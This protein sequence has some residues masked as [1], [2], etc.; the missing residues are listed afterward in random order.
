MSKQA[1]AI[2]SEPY[3][4]IVGETESEAIEGETISVTDPATG[5]VLTDVPAGTVGD[6]ERA[7]ASAAEAFD[8]WRRVPATERGRLLNQLADRILEDQ[9]RLARIETLENGKP[10]SESRDHVRR[11]ARHFEYYGDFAD[12]VQGESIP[13]TEEYVDYTVY[14]P[15]GVTAHIV[16]W[17]VPIYLFARSVAPALA[18]GNTAVVK[19]AEETPL[20]ALEVARLAVDVLPEGVLNVVTGDGSE[21]GAALT[22]SSEVSCVT[23]TGSG[24]TGREVGKAAID[25]VSEVHLELGGKSPFVIYPDADIDA[26]VDETIKGIFTNAGQVCSASSRILVDEWIHDEYVARLADRTDDLTVGAGMEDPNVGPLASAS[27]LEKVERYVDLGREEVGDPVTGG[28]KIDRDGYFFEPTIFDGVDNDMRIA[29]EEIFGPVVT[30]TTFT[31]EEE[32]IRLANDV[33]YG[34]VAGVMT[35]DLGRAHRFA[36]EVDAGQIYVNE[37]FAGGNET[38]FGG[39]KDSGIGRENGLQAVEN[40]TQLKNVCLNISR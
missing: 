19:P 27:H 7:V 4:L 28:K 39:F 24:P 31:T 5:T 26:A 34:L 22:G 32:A 37:W 3:G 40:Y 15:L 10:L 25:N 13:L 1:Q 33:D 14:E 17:N 21:A 2:L 30:V 35:N 18:T 11:C 23:F 8:S 6:V 9:E 29:Q 12:K 16:P 20:G 36:R 38:P